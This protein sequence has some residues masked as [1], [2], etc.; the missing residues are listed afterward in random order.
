MYYRVWCTARSR[1]RTKYRTLQH[2]RQT[3][4]SKQDFNPLTAHMY[5]APHEVGTLVVDGWAWAVTFGTSRR[6]LGRAAA[7]PSLSS[8]YQM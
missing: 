8:L 1:S 5:S 7:H 6:G 4:V 3:Q 2:D